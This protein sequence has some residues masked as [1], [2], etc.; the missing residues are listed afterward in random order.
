MSGAASFKILVSRPHMMQPP[1]VGAGQREGEWR[2]PAE[3]LG[4]RPVCAPR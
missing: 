4:G 1:S 2:R 3:L